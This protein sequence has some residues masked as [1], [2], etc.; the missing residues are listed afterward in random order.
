MFYY[1]LFIFFSS[2]TFFIFYFL[3]LTPLANLLLWHDHVVYVPVW[4][5]CR[6]KSTENRGFRV[7]LLPTV[8]ACMC[9]KNQP[10]QTASLLCRLV[11]PPDTGSRSVPDIIVLWD[12]GV[13][14]WAKFAEQV[15]PLCSLSV[16][17]SRFPF[18]AF[19]SA[20]PLLTVQKISK[21]VPFAA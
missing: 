2:E 10:A 15:L 13:F 3:R 20:F 18:F 9:E 7:R 16:F 1:N 5:H 19:L 12:R 11:V 21:C 6:L 8:C 14:V 17:W 4:I